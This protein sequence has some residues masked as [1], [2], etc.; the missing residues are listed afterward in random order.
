MAG[1]ETD[2]DDELLCGLCYPD[3]SETNNKDNDDNVEPNHEPHENPKSAPT[4][5]PQAWMFCSPMPVAT[6]PCQPGHAEARRA[7][8][9]MRG[10]LF[11]DLVDSL[12]EED[13]PEERLSERK[14]V[15]WKYSNRLSTSSRCAMATFDHAQAGEQDSQQI[16]E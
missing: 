6:R 5:P 13:A 12:D 2:F 10:F 14:K 9:S 15:L 4:G 11:S 7:E 8:S 1:I 3:P 16:V